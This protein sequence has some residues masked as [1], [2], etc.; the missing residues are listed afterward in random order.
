MFSLFNFEMINDWFFL[1]CSVC[2]I[3]ADNLLSYFEQF[4]NESYEDL[5]YVYFVIILV[6]RGFCCSVWL[7]LIM[8]AKGF[9]SIMRL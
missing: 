2:L 8:A 7:A 3:M 9:S 1:L 6:M 5:S 4:V